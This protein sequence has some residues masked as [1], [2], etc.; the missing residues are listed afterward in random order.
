MG[1]VG[2]FG[3]LYV[4]GGVGIVAIDRVIKQTAQAWATILQATLPG[5][6]R[7]AAITRAPVHID[8][9]G[10]LSILCVVSAS[11][12]VSVLNRS[13]DSA[14]FGTGCNAYGEVV[15]PIA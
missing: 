8:D 14:N 15:F 9:R 6:I 11:G 5:G 3:K 7:P 4:S 1:D 2:D 12:G 13:Q 10:D